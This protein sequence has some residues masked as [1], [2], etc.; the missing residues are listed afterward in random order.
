MHMHMHMHMHMWFVEL[1]SQDTFLM[2]SPS[3]AA[4][5]CLPHAQVLW[6]EQDDE[7]FLELVSS[8]D[9]ADSPADLADSPD[10]AD[11]R[12]ETSRPRASTLG[13]AR[14]RA[15]R[16]AASLPAWPSPPPPVFTSCAAAAS[17]EPALPSWTVSLLRSC[18]SPR[19]DVVG[20]CALTLG[21]VYDPP[22][23]AAFAPLSAS[24]V[25]TVLCAIWHF[26]ADIDGRT[27]H[28]AAFVWVELHRVWPA[29]AAQACSPS[30]TSL[31]PPS[32]PVV[33]ATMLHPPFY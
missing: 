32:L 31:A 5:R 9:L 30:N 23:R 20:C 3:R 10:F 28:T 22:C 26:L 19:F 15:P 16:N 14:M 24:C 18:D 7:T 25:T 13:L 27:Q 11:G 2:H 8:T 12:P 21:H 1:R 17:A 33:P 6:K 29:V 4:S